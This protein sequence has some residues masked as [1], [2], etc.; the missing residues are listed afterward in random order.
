[1]AGEVGGTG[2]DCPHALSDFETAVVPQKQSVNWDKL[3]GLATVLAVVA[4]GWTAVGFAVS[5]FL[6]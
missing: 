3:L 6:R 4:L 1:L 5:H 2:P